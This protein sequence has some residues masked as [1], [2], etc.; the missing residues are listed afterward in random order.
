MSK[1]ARWDSSHASYEDRCFTPVIGFDDRPSAFADSSWPWLRGRV[2][3]SVGRPSSR[4]A[5][6]VDAAAG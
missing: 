5:A 6:A 4:I 3:L 2:A 1:L